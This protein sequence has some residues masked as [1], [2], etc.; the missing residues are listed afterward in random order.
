M[1]DTTPRSRWP[2][3]AT[4]LALG[5]ALAR[6]ASGGGATADP[7][8]PEVLPSFTETAHAAGIAH[9]HHK[10][11]LD[12]GLEN[13]MPWMQSVGAAAAAGDFDHDGRID[14]Y[15]TNSDRGE[16]NFL[17]RNDGDGT[18]TDVAAAAGLAAANDARGVSMDCIWGDYDNDGWIDLYLVRWGRNSLYR[19]DGDGTFT[20]VTEHVFRRQD[21]SPGTD[22]ANGNAAIF[23]D[24]DL[25]GRLDIYVGNYFRPVDLFRLQDTRIMHD[26][27]ERARNGGANF[28]YHQEPD[29]SFREVAAALGVDD[30]G[31]TLAVGSADL[32]N[33]GRPDL[34]CANDFG[35]DQLFLGEPGGTFRNVSATALGTDTRKGMNVDFGDFDNDG[36]LD[37]YVTNITTVEYLREG[38]MLWRN[39]G[40]LP[41]IGL[42]MTDVAPETRT[43]DGGWGWGG[44]FLDADLDGDLDIVTVN[45]FISAGPESYWYDL[46]S[47]TVTGVDVA[48]ARNWPPIGD[49]SFSGHE[50]SRLFLNDGR[51][52]FTE[53]AAA[54]G[55]TDDR[56]GRGI[57]CF[58]PDDDGDVDLFVANQGQEPCLYRNDTRTGHHWLGVKLV[59]DPRSGVNRDAVGARVTVVTARGRQIRERDGGNGY[60]AQSEG[61]LHFGLGPAERAQLVAVRWPDGGLQILEDVEADRYLTLHQDPARY[62]SGAALPGGPPR[63]RAR[64]DEAAPASAPR[65]EPAALERLLSGMEQHL[66]ALPPG[67]ALLSTYRRTAAEHGRHDRAIAF[68]GA[69]AAAHPEDPRPRVHHANAF[70]DKLPTCGGLAAIVS[71]GT[72]A[73]KALDELD[74]VLAERPDLWAALYS[75]GMNH[76]HW[77][78]ALRHSDDAA[79][80][81]ER[82]IEIQ[83]RDGG[84]RARS[85]YAR[86]HLALGDARAKA[87]DPAAARRAWRAG[88]D[89]FP[90][91]ASL[92]RR[93]AIPDDRGL[94]EHVEAERSLEQA[95]DTDLSFLDRE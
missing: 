2:W 68:L 44:K 58:D 39:N 88:L 81:F 28:L 32:D 13:I 3:L 1:L 91:D 8:R 46:A 67:H 26:D 42:G 33:D 30:P 75:R 36:W 64:R 51:E 4:A 20:D 6:C 25:D 76:L 55:I 18:F 63:P 5:L 24:Y 78:R 11:T 37:A 38:N 65:I 79:A 77:P 74:R 82:L 53:S 14:L 7:V 69:L 21:G 27:F 10:P 22:W 34:Y 47:W 16:P 31:W 48:D 83:R 84:G 19:N 85:Y 12:P 9:R 52:S 59:A 89:L 80:D 54:A 29:G 70:V 35:P 41:G 66:R 62:V 23:L 49:R 17:Y 87:G 43:W 45:G 60:A 92:A 71:K 50:K 93:L 61:R 90:G 57:V 72:L 73:R 56:D 94:L 40:I 95:I 15:V 86:V